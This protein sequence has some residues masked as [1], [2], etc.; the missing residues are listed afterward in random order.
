MKKLTCILLALVLCAALTACSSGYDPYGILD[1]EHGGDLPADGSQQTED[2]SEATPEEVPSGDA[3]LEPESGEYGCF[4]ELAEPYFTE[5]SYARMECNGFGIDEFGEPYLVY[6]V[7][8]L[9][10]CEYPEPFFVENVAGGA[11]INGMYVSLTLDIPYYLIP[12]EE[13]SAA[14]Y[15]GAAMEELGLT[16]EEVKD[17]W[18]SVDIVHAE[19]AEPLEGLGVGIDIDPNAVL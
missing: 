12:G 7:Y 10:S 6:T 4:V 13:A 1:G 3:A 16:F 18:V 2:I 9:D 15:L 17:V 5:G 11:M 8:C 14:V 19:T